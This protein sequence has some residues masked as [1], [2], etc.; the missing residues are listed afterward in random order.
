MKSLETLNLCKNHLTRLP[1]ELAKSTS[2]AE[3]LLNDNDLIEIPTKIMSMQTLRVLE[4]ERKSFECSLNFLNAFV[5]LLNA[6]FCR[7]LIDFEIHF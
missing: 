7:F 1:L 4:A 5:C 2:L 3:L 6:F